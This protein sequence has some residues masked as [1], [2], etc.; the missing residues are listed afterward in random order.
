MKHK[1]F[2]P[3]VGLEIILVAQHLCY[4]DVHVKKKGMNHVMMKNNAV[5][6]MNVLLKVIYHIPVNFMHNDKIK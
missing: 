2:Y 3:E 4:L 1:S 6:L 5:I